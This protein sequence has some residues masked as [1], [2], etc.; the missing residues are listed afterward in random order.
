MKNQSSAC[1]DYSE[2]QI[3]A[4]IHLLSDQDPKIANT[5]HDRLVAVGQP[6]IGPLQH[7]QGECDTA[8]MADRI[9]A[10]IAA[11][12]LPEI[13]H[14]FQSLVTAK[15][16]ERINLET[17]AFLIAQ[18]GYPDLQVRPYQRQIDDMVDAIREQ[19]EP[20]LTPRQAIQ[21]INQLLFHKLG[22]KGNTR[23]YYDP[24]NSFLHKVL[25]RRMGI[26]ISLSVLY[27]L[28][29]Q[30]LKVPVVGIGL[31]GHFMVGVQ[32]EPVFI[33]CFNQGIVLSQQDVARFLK[34][35]GVEFEPR[36]LNPTPNEQIL[37]RMLRNL[38]AIYQK[39]GETTFAERF[40]RLLAFIEPVDE[41][42][43]QE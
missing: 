15:P 29:G 17:G 24:D 38:V 30:R 22:F 25:E 33:D 43:E 26:P 14:S 40:L 28:I 19:W 2:K 9:G 13:E 36:H 35:Y 20:G 31:P 37:A 23:D 18:A 27:L 1:T 21:T 42:S 12:K 10:V 16:S 41:T 4:L 8:I 3:N 11:I 5:I 39:L 32:T 7:A 34:E 6:A